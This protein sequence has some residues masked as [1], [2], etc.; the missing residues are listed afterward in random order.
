MRQN[1]KKGTEKK[2]N[3]EYKYYQRKKGLA[4]KE[5]KIVKT[6]TEPNNEIDSEYRRLRYADY[7]L[8]FR[9]FGGLHSIFAICRQKP[10]IQS[11]KRKAVLR[12][13]AY[14]A[15]RIRLFYQIYDSKT[16]ACIF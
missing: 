15:E 10:Y 9:P 6:Q 13:L 12:K 1:F 3:T 5:L 16:T 11:I 14:N 7:F 8:I 2:K 4:I